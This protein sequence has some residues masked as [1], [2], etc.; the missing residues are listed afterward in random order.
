MK[1]LSITER[2]ALVREIAEQYNIAQS[3]FNDYVE[4]EKLDITREQF[5]KLRDQTG[6]TH[7]DNKYLDGI[8]RR[9]SYSDWAHYWID[10]NPNIKMIRTT[11]QGWKESDGKWVDKQYA[12][13]YYTEGE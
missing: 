3:Y 13:I 4:F 7:L 1:K 8:Q 12:T 2:F 5:N 6:F 11:K 10:T 9:D